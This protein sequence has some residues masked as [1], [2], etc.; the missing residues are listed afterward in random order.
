MSDKAAVAAI[1]E[2][3]NLEEL[4]PALRERTVRLMRG[5]GEFTVGVARIYAAMLPLAQLINRRKPVSEAELHAVVDHPT[6]QRR[7][8]LPRR[9]G[10][11]RAEVGQT[12]QR[13]LDAGDAVPLV[14][15]RPPHW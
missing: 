1:G 7:W 6:S 5:T 2:Y 13:D 12:L 15:A 8:F 10:D 11:E 4:L 9:R 3:A 14:D